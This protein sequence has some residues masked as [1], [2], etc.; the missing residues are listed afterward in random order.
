MDPN[1]LVSRVIDMVG[2]RGNEAWDE[3]DES[4]ENLLIWWKSG[5]F[6]PN[7]ILNDNPTV[8]IYNQTKTISLRYINGKWSLQQWS[9]LGHDLVW[10]SEKK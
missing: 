8:I 2:D 5:G 4:L 6:A 10:T 3:V 7:V 1:A 9:I